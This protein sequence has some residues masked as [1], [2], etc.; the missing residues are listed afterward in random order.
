[1]I[2]Y[3]NDICKQVLSAPQHFRQTRTNLKVVGVFSIISI[4]PS[5]TRARVINLYKVIVKKCGLAK[6][7]CVIDLLWSL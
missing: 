2:H 3:L 4:I 1:M 5:G 7:Y 6:A